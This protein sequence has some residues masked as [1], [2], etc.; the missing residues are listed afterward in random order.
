MPMKQFILSSV[1]MLLFSFNGNAQLQVDY[2]GK[3][4]VSSTNPD[5]VA[6]LSVGNNCHLGGDY[7][8]GIASTPLLQESKRNVGVEGYIN[9][10]NS[11]FTSDTNIGV[12]GYAKMNKNHGHN[13]GVLGTIDYDYAPICVGG[14]GV[15]ATSHG[16]YA[17]FPAN[18]Q[19]MYALYVA[20]SS[21]LNGSTTAQAIYTP[22][23]ESLC[24]NV[25]SMGTRD[26]DSTLDNLLKM[27]VR[28]FN[29]K[30]TENTEAPR[31]GEKMS[32]EVRKSYELIK[33]EEE[34]MYARRHFGLSAQELQKIY[35]N[36]V[37]KAQDGYL[38]VNYTELVP[39]LIRCIQELKA[40]L[41]ELKAKKDN[42]TESNMT[43]FEGE[44][45]QISLK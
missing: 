45:I 4:A 23:D 44:D 8:L 7:S 3:V 14:A 6:R 43:G 21:Q 33:K 29:I 26:G 36:L 38:Y 37:L 35:P 16:Y 34:E 40:E 24:D 12:M 13:F 5:F 18:V 25:E 32:E 15:Y 28:E 22:A 1:L 17:Y 41:D 10:W 19:G 11:S 42:E 2:A 31:D 30:N 27:N 9:A 20:G 39:I